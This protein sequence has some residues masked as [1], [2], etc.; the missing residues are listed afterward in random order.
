MEPGLAEYIVKTADF[1]ND[2]DITTNGSSSSTESKSYACD[3]M[4]SGENGIDALHDHD[5]SSE[6]S[7][8]C[9]SVCLDLPQRAQEIDDNSK[10]SYDGLTALIKENGMNAE[11]TSVV[12]AEL[13]REKIYDAS[14]SLL[15]NY[16]RNNENKGDSNLKTTECVVLCSDN[17]NSTSK[18]EKDSILLPN[19][20]LNDAGLTETPDSAV[21]DITVTVKHVEMPMECDG[22]QIVMKSCKIETESNDSL[23][24]TGRLEKDD[25]LFPKNDLNDAGLTESRGGAISNV[26]VKVEQIEMPMEIDGSQVV[27]NGCKIETELKSAVFES[28]MVPSG[29]SAVQESSLLVNGLKKIADCK[30]GDVMVRN[31][32]DSVSTE[33]AGTSSTLNEMVIRTT[34]PLNFVAKTTVAGAKIT[35]SVSNK[36]A[37][38]ITIKSTSQQSLPSL[39]DVDYRPVGKLLYTLGLDL[40]REQAYAGIL[41]TSSKMDKV[42]ETLKEQVER[43]ME[44]HKKLA[45]EN[46]IFHPRELKCKCGFHTASKNALVLHQEEGY[47]NES[48]VSRTSCCMCNFASSLPHA[49]AS[50]MK[51]VHKVKWRQPGKAMNFTCQLCTASFNDRNSFAKHTPRCQLSFQLAQNLQPRE[52]HDCDFPLSKSVLVVRAPEHNYSDYLLRAAQLRPSAPGVVAPRTSLTPMSRPVMTM[53]MTMSGATARGMLTDLRDRHIAAQ[54][55]IQPIMP[56]PDMQSVILQ[57]SMFAAQSLFQSQSVAGQIA[58]P[59]QVP[60]WGTMVLPNSFI[61]P[62]ACRPSPAMLPMVQI[63]GTLYRI[64]PNNGQPLFN[65]ANIPISS[66][67]QNFT[68]SPQTINQQN[69]RV[70]RLPQPVMPSSRPQ[71]LVV[72]RSAFQQPKSESVPSLR[73]PKLES[74][75]SLKVAGPPSNTAIVRSANPTSNLKAASLV[76][77]S[78]AKKTPYEI[79]EICGGFVKDREALWIH[80][81]S[82]HR[83]DMKKDIVINGNPAVRC[84]HCPD[85]FWTLCGLQRHKKSAHDIDAATDLTDKIVPCLVCGAGK[86]ATELIG[87]ICSDHPEVI[88]KMFE[89]M[90]C[91][92]CNINLKTCDVVEKHM[93]GDHPSLFP[94]RTILQQMFKVTSDVARKVLNSKPKPARGRPRSSTKHASEA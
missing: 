69:A 31:I 16:D 22:S 8:D 86:K 59:I 56:A 79:C 91:A 14:E 34:V 94:D 83:I 78:T 87:H 4:H 84:S 53:P 63:G 60:A 3:D 70:V 67:I 32:L 43:L 13:V 58:S 40:A 18:V 64:M 74:A 88:M 10:S 37:T 81:Y 36:P 50:H 75:P 65:P 11:I 30:S 89:T 92:L 15:D 9:S 52:Q 55:L 44:T 93:L 80:F 66:G 35:A 21:S 12:C 39:N 85:G 25:I 23:N 1:T 49:F 28:S 73:L 71:L 27:M 77:S 61:P 6:L 24:S 17:L 68:A 54:R 57:Q 90:Q 82:S 41:H 2:L 5:S 20:D 38:V 7:V 47:I 76:D 26:T 33:N 42:E 46:K 62:S 29:P 19:K 48:W 45:R 51:R 72:P